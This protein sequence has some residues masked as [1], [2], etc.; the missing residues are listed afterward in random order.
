MK[1]LTVAPPPVSIA[2]NSLSS[3]I[4]KI[5]SSVGYDVEVLFDINN[6]PASQ[7]ILLGNNLQSKFSNFFQRQYEI[8]VVEWKMLTTLAREPNVTMSQI[9][10]EIGIDKAAVSR[11]LS[12]LAEKRLIIATTACTNARSK[13]WQLTP[14]GTALHD[15]I[16]KAN[17]K[18]IQEILKGIPRESLAVMSE[19]METI[20]H[21]IQQMNW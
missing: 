6:N 17:M 2:K 12:K 8:G 1:T 10:E 20:E 7:T 5:P 9:T 4:N 16:F 15:V 13:L 18:N 3:A 21:N 11:A 19:V 14:A